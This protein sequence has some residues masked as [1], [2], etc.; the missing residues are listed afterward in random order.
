ME[1]HQILIVDDDEKIRY[2]FK[3]VFNKDGYLF[4]EA[5]D[6]LEA[7][8]LIKD[9]PPDIIFMDINMPQVDGLDVLKKINDLDYNI[10]V[11]IITG[12]GTMQTAIQAMKLGAFQYLVKPLSVAHIREEIKKAIVSI[13]SAKS[14]EFLFDIDVSN[15]ATG[16]DLHNDLYNLDAS[17]FAPMSHDAQYVYNGD[18]GDGGDGGDSCNPLNPFDPCEISEPKVLGLM[19]AALLSLFLFYSMK[20]FTVRQT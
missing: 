18:G 9:S 6:G 4:Q 16:I 8:K 17:L 1:K 10:P 15:L 7:L 12:K 19:F 2:A 11:I 3:E 13:K 20:G 5:K 14:P